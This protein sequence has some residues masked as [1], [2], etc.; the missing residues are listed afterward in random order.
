MATLYHQLQI[1]ATPAVIYQA[2]TT[3]DGIGS[4]WDRPQL[5][6]HDGRPP[7]WSF[8]PGPGHGVLTMQI[9]QTQPEQLVLWRCTSH[10]A[11]SS[12][13]SAWADTLL[14]F[15]LHTPNGGPDTTLDFRHSGCAGQFPRSACESL[16]DSP[17]R[18]CPVSHQI[19][20]LEPSSTTALLGRPRKSAAPLA[21]WCICANSF[22]RQGAMPSPSRGTTLSRERK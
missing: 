3:E 19:S 20:T 9:L 2:L 17:A 21:L 11:A 4:W 7:A 16:P 12:P 22:S 10:H 6:L 13:A 18:C 8:R 15:E 5:E 1:K 14:R